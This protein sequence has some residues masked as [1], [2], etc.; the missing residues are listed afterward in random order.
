MTSFRELGAQQGAV[1]TGSLH[2][3]YR[4]SGG[5]EWP[6]SVWAGQGP[7]EYQGLAIKVS[8]SRNSEHSSLSPGKEIVFLLHLCRPGLDRDRVY[9]DAR[10]AQVWPGSLTPW[11]LLGWRALRM[12]LLAPVAP[13]P[14]V[15]GPSLRLL[16]VGL[17]RCSFNEA[18]RGL[19]EDSFAGFPR[20]I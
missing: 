15:G 20:P 1:V 19:F 16:W 3:I 17:S 8:L 2:P 11:P 13:V 4:K 10:L 9:L 18:L 6:D 14:G 12:R 7:E 5:M